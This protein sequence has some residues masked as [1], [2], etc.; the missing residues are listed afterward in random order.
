MSAA[1]FVLDGKATFLQIKLAT[2]KPQPQPGGTLHGFNNLQ[3]MISYVLLF[4]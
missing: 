4:Y 1:A 3:T 2:L